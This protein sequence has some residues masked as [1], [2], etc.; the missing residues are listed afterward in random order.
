MQYEHFGT[1]AEKK[2]YNCNF[3][4][5]GLFERFGWTFLRD[6]EEHRDSEKR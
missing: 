1:F 6:P 5:D 2:K 4:A 3:L